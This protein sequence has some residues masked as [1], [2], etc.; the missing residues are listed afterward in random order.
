[1]RIYT[2][3]DDFLLTKNATLELKCTEDH[4]NEA[5][6]AFGLSTKRFLRNRK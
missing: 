1:M 5:L 6:L 2:I 3:D 4:E